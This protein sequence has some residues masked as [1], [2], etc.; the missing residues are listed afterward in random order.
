MTS[1]SLLLQRFG[2][3]GMTL[4][5]ELKVQLGETL[6]NISLSNL[7]WELQAAITT[8]PTETSKQTTTYYQSKIS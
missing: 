3:K 7:L 4:Q 5:L 6:R 8:P 1:L 2:T